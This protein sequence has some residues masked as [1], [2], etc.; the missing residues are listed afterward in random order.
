MGSCGEESKGIK[1]RRQRKK[2]QREQEYRGE[3]SL[4]WRR[5]HV[6]PRE[7]G[8]IHERKDESDRDSRREERRDHGLNELII[9]EEE[10]EDERGEQRHEQDH[11][12]G[13]AE[14]Q[15]AEIP[16]EGGHEERGDNHA[17]EHGPQDEQPGG[18]EQL[19]EPQG[20]T[21]SR[22]SVFGRTR[23]DVR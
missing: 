22:S 10:P 6:D 7:G 19:P 16:E 4:V 21:S 17:T 2:N 15:D 18:Q 11:D 14:P 13:I 1:G 20:I 3:C 5:P 12:P 9:H 23:C 8:C